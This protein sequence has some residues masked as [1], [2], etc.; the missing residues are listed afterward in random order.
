MSWDIKK[1]KQ[2]G[3]PRESPGTATLAGFKENVVILL[4]GSCSLRF[5]EHVPMFW[6]IYSAY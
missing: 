1:T 3:R 5:E 6:T 4:Q 2:S